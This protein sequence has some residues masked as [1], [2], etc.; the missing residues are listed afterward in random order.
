MFKKMIPGLAGG[1]CLGFLV[2][3]AAGLSG[4]V[5][6]QVPESYVWVGIGIGIVLALSAS[7]PRISWRRTLLATGILCLALSPIALLGRGGGVI[8]SEMDFGHFAISATVLA[9]LSI[10]IGVS[11]IYGA[12]LLSERSP[13]IV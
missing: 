4:I 5:G 11:C 3:T 10:L 9:G 7:N 12:R 2:P 8:N 6:P 1:F 13:E